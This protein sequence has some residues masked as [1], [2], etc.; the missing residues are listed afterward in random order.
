MSSPA[1][2]VEHTYTSFLIAG[3]SF[4]VDVSSVKE[5]VKYKELLPL[6]EPL[7]DVEGF[8]ELHSLCIPVFNTSKILSLESAVAEKGIMIVNVDAHIIGLMVDIDADIEVFSS[9]STPRPLKGAEPMNNYI[10][11]TLMHTERIINVLSLSSLVNAEKRARLF[12]DG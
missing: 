9:L 4:A 12:A 7:E 2:G 1:S 3:L 8:I 6:S 5:I 11:G 10:L